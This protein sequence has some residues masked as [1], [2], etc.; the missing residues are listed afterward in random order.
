MSPLLFRV[1]PHILGGWWDPVSYLPLWPRGHSGSLP[2]LLARPCCSNSRCLTHGRRPSSLCPPF[3][4]GHLHALGVGSQPSHRGHCP[5]CHALCASKAPPPRS[6]PQTSHPLW[7][8]P[9]PSRTKPELLGAAP[10]TL[11]S[12][13]GGAVDKPNP[14]PSQDWP[15]TQPPVPCTHGAA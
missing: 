1:R 4:T 5:F 12:R 10:S 9:C 15:R 6:G 13:H 2:R 11:G 14:K 3:E 7:S 8:A